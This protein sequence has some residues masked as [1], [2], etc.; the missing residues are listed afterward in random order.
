MNFFPE[1][2]SIGEDPLHPVLIVSAIK[3][4]FLE[5]S[6]DIFE[7]ADISGVSK[8]SPL[9]QALP[10]ALTSQHVA[11][12]NFMEVIIDGPLAKTKEG[13]GFRAFSFGDNGKIKEHAV[14]MDA[15]K[16]SNLVNTGLLLQTASVLLA[17]KHLADINEKLVLISEDVKKISDFQSNNRASKIS[18]GIKYLRQITPGLHNGDLSPVIRQ[19]LEDFEVQF[20]SIQDHLFRDITLIN[21]E[22]ENCA[23][24]DF[25]GTD[26][27][28]KEIKKRQEIIKKHI[29]EWKM[30]LSVRIYALQ[31][32]S[33][34][35]GDV[36]L[37][38]ERNN[39]IRQDIENFKGILNDIA[40][41]QRKRISNISAFMESSNS[42]NA[43]KVLLNKWLTLYLFPQTQ[44]TNE[45]LCDYDK[46][47]LDLST[48]DAK[49][50][51]LI[52][53]MENGKLVKLYK[54]K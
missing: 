15:D 20:I 10:T 24:P 34:F 43:N 14:L 39:S 53:E 16:L 46:F 42:T 52:V 29:I 18:S 30:A 13:V 27:I 54:E 38:K 25:F 19:K 48:A 47:S 51:R 22:V 41:V 4:S 44:H 28:T 8:L 50:T 12:H 6:I 11:Q 35:D 17:Q 1:K 21:K 23:D 2:V 40:H 26:G 49:P 32:I 36:S 33:L 5:A 31:L 3:P 9:L 45:L 37:Q 7:E